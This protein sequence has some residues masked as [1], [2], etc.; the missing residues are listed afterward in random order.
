MPAPPNWQSHTLLECL[1][2]FGFVCLFFKWLLLMAL[3]ARSLRFSHWFFSHKSC[4]SRLYIVDIKHT[5]VI[6]SSNCD[7]YLAVLVQLNLNRHKDFLSMLRDLYSFWNTAGYFSSGRKLH[8][9]VLF[10]GTTSMV[11]ETI[12]W[13]LI[14]QITTC[15]EPQAFCIREVLKCVHFVYFITHRNLVSLDWCR[16]SQPDNFYELVNI[17]CLSA[18]LV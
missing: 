8:L 2:S 13:K 11:T 9:P 18:R 7:L 16:V 3:L 5:N 12:T 14:S 10:I 1:L 15:L 6:C 17:Q 4:I